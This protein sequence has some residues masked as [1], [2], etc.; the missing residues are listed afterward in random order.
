MST[1][2]K[3][4][5]PAESLQLIRSMIE[6]TKSSISDNSHFFL[7]WGWATFVGCLLQYY[8]LVI[9]NYPHHY[10]AWLVTPVA[11]LLHFIFIRKQRKQQRVKTFIGETIGFIWFILGFSYLALAIVFVKMAGN[12]VF[13]FISCYIVSEHIFRGAYFHLGL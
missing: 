6:T 3:D 2:N 11:L 4:F 8:L 9:A 12:I 7:L 5:S 13:L 10:Y 1:S